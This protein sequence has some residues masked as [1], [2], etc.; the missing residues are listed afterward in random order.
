M[1]P[2]RKKA[3]F[4]FFFFFFFFCTLFFCDSFQLMRCMKICTMTTTYVVCRSFP[5][6][7]MARGGEE[8]GI[9]IFG[10]AVT[11]ERGAKVI[12]FRP[13]SR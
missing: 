12:T 1:N 9:H 11:T 2:S 6:S 13:P 4:F 8:M 7:N 5:S 3:A 10:G